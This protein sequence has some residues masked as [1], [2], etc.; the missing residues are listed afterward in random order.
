MVDDSSAPIVLLDFD[1]VLNAFPDAIDVRYED[2]GVA[3][4]VECRGRMTDDFGPERAFPFG[5]CGDRAAGPQGRHVASA[6]VARAGRRPGLPASHRSGREHLGRRRGRGS[7]PGAAR[8]AGPAKHH[9]RLQAGRTAVG[10]G[11]ARCDH[12]HHRHR[13]PGRNRDLT[14]AGSCV[15]GVGSCASMRSSCPPVLP[16]PACSGAR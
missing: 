16:D 2:V 4:V 3:P 14:M 15:R 10:R 7:R 6:L 9:R 13:R 11:A 5:W 8:H 12:V 1:G